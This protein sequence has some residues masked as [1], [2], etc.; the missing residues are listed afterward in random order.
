[1]VSAGPG[2][3]IVD[4]TSRLREFGRRAGHDAVVSDG[5]VLDWPRLVERLER[6][7]A[8][9]HAA[10]IGPG[11]TVGISIADEV[12]H[13]IAALALIGAG[14]W[15]IALATHDTEPERHEIAARAGVTHVLLGGGGEP[16]TG[17]LAHLL[18]PLPPG[19]ASPPAEDGG[20]LLRTSGTTGSSNIVPLTARDL[21]LQ[22]ERNREYGDGRLLRPA[23]IEHNNSKRH[24]LY[25]AALGGTN[26]FRPQGP[27]DMAGYCEQA[28]VTTLDLSLMQAADLASVTRAGLDGVELRVSGSAVPFAVRSALM[29]NVSRRLYVRYGSTETGT[30]S[31]AGP[32]EHDED[33][34]V[35]R[36]VD[37]LD[38]EIVAEDGSPLPVG[39]AGHIRIRGQGIARGYHGDEEQTGKRFR[40]GWFWPGDLGVFTAARTLRILG[41]ADDMIN[42]NGINIFPSEIERVLEQHPDVV[43]AAAL[44]L[45]SAVHGQIPVAA[46]ELREGGLAT[47]RD[48]V[49]YAREYMALRAPRRVIIVPALPR[50]SQGKIL[51]RELAAW[52]GAGGPGA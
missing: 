18:W 48:I 30:V 23:S 26:V 13:F 35:G 7:I 4:L 22:A 34:S 2:G 3:A 46:V 50:N 25:C 28:G 11:A 45:Y 10:G 31:V 43:A 44:P 38:V 49:A 17:A 33:Q 52:F 15:Q 5:A 16:R 51:R 41:R 20:I 32:G 9:L 19:G 8:A 1:M 42:L 39:E 40:Q 21:L 24:R 47:P 27:Y 12:E 6:E 37:G 29:Q 14:A 36:V